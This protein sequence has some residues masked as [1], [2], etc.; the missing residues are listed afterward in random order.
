MTAGTKVIAKQ[1]AARDM[2]AQYR[3]L[4]EGLPVV[5]PY[6]RPEAILEADP[7]ALRILLQSYYPLCASFHA[8]F[9]E[10]IETRGMEPL[11]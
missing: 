4:G 2:C 8:S 3:V 11:S 7:D 5:L 10:I 9:Q 1:G 6:I